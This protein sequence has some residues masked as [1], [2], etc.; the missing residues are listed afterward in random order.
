VPG[1]NQTRWWRFAPVQP[2]PLHQVLLRSLSAQGLAHP[3]ARLHPAPVEGDV[4]VFKVEELQTRSGDG[5]IC[6]F[7]IFFLLNQKHKK[8]KKKT[9]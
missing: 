6:H 1:Q 2:L 8:K 7:Y 9:K 4:L 5:I 3:Q